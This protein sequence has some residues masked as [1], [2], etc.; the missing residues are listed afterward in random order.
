MPVSRWTTASLLLFLL[1][2]SA[3]AAD[4]EGKGPLRSWPYQDLQKH[5]PPNVHLMLDQR[6][7]EMFLAALDDRP[8]DWASVYGHGHHDP[9]HDDRLFT[10]NRERD[11]KR[12]GRLA[13]AW[14]IAFVWSG[15]LSS[16][17][18]AERGFPL[19]LGPKFMRTS[20][21]MVRFKPDE[22]PGNLVVVPEPG[23]RRRLQTQLTKGEPVEID[24]L[25]TG[26]LI[27]NESLV[28]DFS[29]DEEGLGLIMPFVRVER[30]DYLM[31]TSTPGTPKK[32]RP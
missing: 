2:S 19:S 1:A 17:N 4:P 12:E 6:S 20:W 3:W 30:I 23:Q 11:A 29:H 10:L 28:Y 32:S 26:R 22:A 25:M 27:P 13:L 15:T 5:L 9:G 31:P 18:Q 21:G 14:P 7:V 16:Y 24:V 8:P